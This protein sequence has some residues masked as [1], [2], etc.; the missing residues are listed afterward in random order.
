MSI[1]PIN[2]RCPTTAP[3]AYPPLEQ[4]TRPTV[5]TAQAAYYLDRLP[6]TLR[7]WSCKSGRGPLKPI[8]VHGRLAW[9]VA[10]IKRLLELDAECG[11]GGRHE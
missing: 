7:V 6:Q 3:A 4:V 1:I 9:P 10:E 2:S 8:R 5:P 11:A